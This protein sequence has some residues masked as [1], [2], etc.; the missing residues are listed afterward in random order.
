MS[1]K[2]TKTMISTKQSKISDIYDIFVT[3]PEC[4]KIFYRNKLKLDWLGEK[5]EKKEIC[6]LEN[7]VMNYA[8]KN[9]EILFRAGF[10]YAWSL[11]FEC[12]QQNEIYKISN[13]KSNKK[14]K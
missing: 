9:D 4:Y 6:D 2:S 7:Q 8:S 10:H 3:S 11:F 14:I 5:L 1:K 12:I 13:K